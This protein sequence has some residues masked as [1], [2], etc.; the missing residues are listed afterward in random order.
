MKT[1]RRRRAV[2]LI[3]RLLTEGDTPLANAFSVATGIFIGCLPLY[4]LH[5]LLSV[6]AARLLGLSRLKTFLASNLSIPVVIPVLLLVE[7]Q[8]GSWL[9]RGEF[10][11]LS[12]DAFTRT[13]PWDF[14]ADLMLG[15]V[16]VGALLGGLGFV[17]TLALIPP[18]RTETPRRELIERAARRYLDLGIR[19]WWRVRQELGRD[20]LLLT[21]VTGGFLP[22][23]GQLVHLGCGRGAF[24]ALVIVFR[25]Y[26]KERPLPS[27]W[28]PLSRHLRLHGIEAGSDRAEIA[29]GA[30][31]A[32]AT[33]ATAGPAVARIPACEAVVLLD[34]LHDLPRDARRDLLLRAK[35]ALSKG[36]LLVLG[37]ARAGAHWSSIVGRIDRRVRALIPRGHDGN[38]Y[39]R[40]TE[41]YTR[42][43]AG[44]G[45]AVSPAPDAIGAS[46]RH[47]LLLGRK[48]E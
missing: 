17:V 27:G 12:R 47:A 41:E 36:G 32:E 4:G 16:I 30:L 15:S 11:G 6:V 48:P 25:E 21:V 43:L 18:G 29:R 44:A 1:E 31:G 2:E 45:F 24:L 20:R 46:F 37:E 13:S 7:I 19:E 40:T 10:Y 33:V 42:L 8:T 5:W 35:T 38:P 34:I 22:E 28:T 3:H 39:R 23:R 9:R 26:A 14:P